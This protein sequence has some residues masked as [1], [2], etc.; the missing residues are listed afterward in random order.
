VEPRPQ[1]YPG[2]EEAHEQEGSTEEV[3]EVEANEIEDGETEEGEGDMAIDVEKGTLV[4]ENGT[5]SEEHAVVK[6]SERV[7]WYAK[8]QQYTLI[9]NTPPSANEH[10]W[11][12]E[13]PVEIPIIVMQGTLSKW[14]RI[15]PSA[16]GGGATYGYSIAPPPPPGAPRP[17]PEI[18]PEP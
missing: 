16:T 14:Y 15:R 5:V 18:I 2:R 6:R 10:P 12:F 4:L 1:A 3:R 11:P 17:G 7:R 9:F 8:D 13:D